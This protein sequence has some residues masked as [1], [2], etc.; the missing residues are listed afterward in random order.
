MS[1]KL[2]KKLEILFDAL[3]AKGDKEKACKIGDILDK[4]EDGGIYSSIDKEIVGNV[5]NLL[6]LGK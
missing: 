4:V 5:E 3:M 2:L 6:A 1:E